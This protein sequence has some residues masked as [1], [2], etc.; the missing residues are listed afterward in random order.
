MP[1]GAAFQPGPAPVEDRADRK[2]EQDSEGAVERSSTRGNEAQ[3]VRGEAKL[4]RSAGNRVVDSTPGPATERRGG[5]VIRRSQLPEGLPDAERSRHIGL[6]QTLTPGYEVAA[7]KPR[8][9]TP[10]ARQQV[11]P[12]VVDQIEVAV[13]ERL[14]Q[15]QL[16][17]GGSAM[18]GL[19]RSL[20]T[21]PN[22]LLDDR[23]DCQSLT[24]KTQ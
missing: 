20:L 10:R 5:R 1:P 22:A 8:L 14:E 23:V 19:G 7:H 24:I 15:R 3:L 12:P 9:K 11:G 13:Q 21:P 17:G 2:A 16:P 4:D 18:A 6:A